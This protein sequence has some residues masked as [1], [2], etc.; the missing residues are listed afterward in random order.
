ML[1][2]V[3]IPLYNKERYISSA[4]ASVLAQHHQDFEIVVVDDGSLDGGAAVVA[5]MEDA[6][7]RL[8]RQA[9]GGVSRARNAGIA[10]RAA[11]W[12]VSSMPMT[13]M[14]LPSSRCWWITDCP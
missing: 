11:N 5:A 14:A 12:C 13:G 7:I 6:R 8:I 4:I 9:N 1:C 2:S 10:A 3:I